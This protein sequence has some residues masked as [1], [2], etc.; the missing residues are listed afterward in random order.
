[1]TGYCK[2]GVGTYI[3]PYLFQYIPGHAALS[4]SLFVP[5]VH[6]ILVTWK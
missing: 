2:I 6:E 1:M 4:I 5:A 3:S